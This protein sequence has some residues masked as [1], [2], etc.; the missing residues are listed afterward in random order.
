MF[1]VYSRSSSIGWFPWPCSNSMLQMSNWFCHCIHAAFMLPAWQPKMMPSSVRKLPFRIKHQYNDQI[2]KLG[3]YFP[4]MAFIFFTIWDHSFQVTNMA[5]F[6]V[7]SWDPPTQMHFQPGRLHQPHGPRF[8][9]TLPFRHAKTMA[10][11]SNMHN[12]VYIYIYMY[13]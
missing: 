3:F 4:T 7:P 6:S 8:P 1:N 5:T 2:V 10:M 12:I 9:E 13:F 11:P